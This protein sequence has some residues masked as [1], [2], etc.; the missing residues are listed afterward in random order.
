MSDIT[1][2]SDMT[3]DLINFMGNDD[4]VIRA[5]K[6]STATDFT[7]DEQQRWANRHNKPTVYGHDIYYREEE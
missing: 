1:F 7:V 4:S 2:R 3:V 5:A 6:V